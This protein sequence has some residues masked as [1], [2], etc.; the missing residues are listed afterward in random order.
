[1]Y[2]LK[3][4]VNWHLGDSTVFLSHLSHLLCLWVVTA[5]VRPSRGGQSSAVLHSSHTGLTHTLGLHKCLWFNL[6]AWE[7]R[8]SKLPSRGPSAS[9]SCLK[10]MGQMLNKECLRSKER[11]HCLSWKFERGHHW[12]VTHGHLLLKIISCSYYWRIPETFRTKM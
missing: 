1:M 2:V 4:S 10:W 8:D 7:V 12:Y 3:R 5:P 11:F 6:I 9:Y